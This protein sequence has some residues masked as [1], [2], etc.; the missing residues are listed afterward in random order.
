VLIPPPATQ[1][2]IGAIMGALDEKMALHREI[3]AVTEQLR[4][5]LLPLLLAKRRA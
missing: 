1:E 3:V 2:V 5:S 4:D